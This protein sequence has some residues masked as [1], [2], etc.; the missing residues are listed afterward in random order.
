MFRVGA[1]LGLTT[2][3]VFIGRLYGVSISGTQLVTI[4]LTAVITSFS[5]PGIPGGSIIAMAPVLASAGLPL[6]G[7]GI[8]LGVDTIPDMFRTAAN[9]T[10][11]LAAATIVA[12]GAPAEPGVSPATVDV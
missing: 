8:L 9:V 12:R 11:Q 6:E 2:G 3:A 5:I 10:G 4:V 1:T 7:I